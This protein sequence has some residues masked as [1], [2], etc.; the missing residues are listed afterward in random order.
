MWERGCRVSDGGEG[1]PQAI[2]RIWYQWVADVEHIWQGRAWDDQAQAAVVVSLEA[3]KARYGIDGRTPYNY[4]LF[5]KHR[6]DRLY[7]SQLVW[8]VYQGAEID[9]DSNDPHYAVMMALRAAIYPFLSAQDGAVIARLAVAP[10]EIA[11]DDDLQFVG[12]LEA[13]RD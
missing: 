10:D 7:C 8:K 1:I 5:D 12:L 4:R 2:N 11:L 6:D 3:A 13:Q 9:L